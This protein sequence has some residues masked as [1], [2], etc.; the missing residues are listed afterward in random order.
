MQAARLLAT[1]MMLRAPAERGFMA[2]L[3]RRIIT[4]RTARQREA[5]AAIVALVIPAVEIAAAAGTA[6]VVEINEL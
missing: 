6:V 3:T 2:T 4:T 1:S 5:V